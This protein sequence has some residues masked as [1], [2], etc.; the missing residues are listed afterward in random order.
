VRIFGKKVN[1]VTCVAVPVI[2]IAAA[3]AGCSGDK[4][5]GAANGSAP[6]SA[7]APIQ[8]A[9]AAPASE[10]QTSSPTSSETGQA[11]LPE[12]VALKPEG[13]PVDGTNRTKTGEVICDQS[14][15][16]IPLDLGDITYV[17]AGASKAQIAAYQEGILGITIEISDGPS[18]LYALIADGE[19]ATVIPR[20]L[21][22]ARSSIL[23]LD[24]TDWSKIEKVV[25]CASVE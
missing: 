3:L 12:R 9:S 13:E 19:A 8:S 25:A 21:R 7:A 6:P 23:G 11:T 17:G 5:S 10:V 20:E 18:V 24:T 4:P 2:I 22:A 15:L 14:L 1:S 16:T